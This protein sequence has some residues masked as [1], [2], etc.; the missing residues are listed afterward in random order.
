MRGRAERI[1]G[2][3]S[4]GQS[5]RSGHV[6]LQT[7]SVPLTLRGM[8][9]PRHRPRSS[10]RLIF[11]LLSVL[12]L[13]AFA[14]V[15][16]LAG[17]EEC[18]DSS[19]K[20]YE[21]EIPTAGG[22]DNKSE[23]NKSG[24]QGEAKAGASEAPE[25]NQAHTQPSEENLD[26]EPEEGKGAAAPGNNGSN[27]PADKGNSSS[28]N[29]SNQASTGIGDEQSLGGNTAQGQNASNPGGGSSSSGGGSS[30]L[31]PILVAIAALAAISIGAVIY[32]QRRQGSGGSGSPVSPNA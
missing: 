7:P 26:E 10:A 4:Q 6:A 8:R 22:K 32:R 23:K 1:R 16:A 27:G 31:V 18:T 11:S 30:P 9:R 28:G 21:V 5:H 25:G 13:L 2:R 3:H 24:S 20:Q 14:C 12:A 19:C 17:A 15:P 29:G